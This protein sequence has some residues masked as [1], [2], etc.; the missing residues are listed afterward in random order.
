MITCPEWASLKRTSD[1]MSF[2]M[3]RPASTSIS[4]PVASNSV[5]GKLY[6]GKN[7]N[8]ISTR[9]I[10]E[11]EQDYQL[12][13]TKGPK[14]S[15]AAPSPKPKLKKS[16][17][18]L[19]MEKRT[20]ELC[21]KAIIQNALNELLGSRQSITGFVQ[22]LLAQRIKAI[23]NIA[24]TGKMNGFSFEYSGISFKAS[25]LGKSYSWTALQ[26]KLDYQPERDNA[27]LFKLSR[28]AP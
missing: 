21:P 5:R 16:R 12:T 24:S 10:E 18:E 23:P 8:L 4:S 13:R 1:A 27:F 9:I 15:P 22:Q 20:G 14:A 3:M 26:D 2:M 19:M 6:L 17:N 25:Q 11:L 7:E 28:L